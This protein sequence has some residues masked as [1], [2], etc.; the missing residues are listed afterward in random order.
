MP[1]YLVTSGLP[2]HPAGLTDKEASL[3]LPLYRA[4]NN[5]AQ[6]VSVLSSN[7]QYSAS[8]MAQASQVTKLV[9]A[10]RNKIFV[11]AFENMNYGTLVSIYDNAGVITARKADHAV[12]YGAHGVIDTPVGVVAGEYCEILFMAGHSFGITGT[13]VGQPYWLSTAGQV[14]AT[15]PGTG[16]VQ[17]IGWG[18]GSSGFYLNIAL[19]I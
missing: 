7:T 5:V 13:V 12:P 11:R 15:K 2:T 8:E 3:V 4:V 10:K 19:P 6:S 17:P 14:Q 16:I 18:L 9:A 1:E